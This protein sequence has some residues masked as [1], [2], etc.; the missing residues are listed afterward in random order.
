MSCFQLL[1][2]TCEDYKV[3]SIA[4][5]ISSFYKKAFGEAGYTQKAVGNDWSQNACDFFFISL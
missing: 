5:C 2:Q 3:W 4:V 1:F